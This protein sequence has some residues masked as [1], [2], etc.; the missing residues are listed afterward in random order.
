MCVA[1]GNAQVD[2]TLQIVKDAEDHL[3]ITKMKAEEAQDKLRQVST[4]VQT[5]NEY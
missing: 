2:V 4:S 3:E 1:T 5:G